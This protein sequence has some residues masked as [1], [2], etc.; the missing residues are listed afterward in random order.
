VDQCRNILL[1]YNILC[2]QRSFTANMEKNPNHHR[3]VT[4]S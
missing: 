1:H 4:T 3:F 2:S